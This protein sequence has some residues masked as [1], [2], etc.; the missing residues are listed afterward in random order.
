MQRTPN[1]P[2]AA[3]ALSKPASAKPPDIVSE[4]VPDTLAALH[5]NPETGLTGVG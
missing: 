4:T 2:E 3:S 1:K 5:V